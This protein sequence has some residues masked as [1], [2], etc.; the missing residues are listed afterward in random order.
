LAVAVSALG[1]GEA[2]DSPRS[3]LAHFAQEKPTFSIRSHVA[4]RRTG[5]FPQLF[6]SPGLRTREIFQHFWAGAGN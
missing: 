3:Q 4:L 1:L 6:P 5:S 2:F